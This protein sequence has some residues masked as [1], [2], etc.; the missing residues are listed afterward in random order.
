MST[1]NGERTAASIGCEPSDGLVRNL[2]GAFIAGDGEQPIVPR[3]YE[4]GR[5]RHGQLS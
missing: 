1:D 2:L 5:F 3:R 4:D